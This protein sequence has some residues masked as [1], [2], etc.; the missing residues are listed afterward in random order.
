MKNQILSISQ[1]ILIEPRLER[2]VNY[3]IQVNKKAL[4][5]DIYWHNEW[6]LN[7]KPY[8]KPLIGSESD[9]DILSD[10]IYWDMIHDYLNE[11]TP[12]LL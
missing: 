3:C 9:N 8:I 11:I 10:S 12:N 7:I 1:I 6:A 2:I 4:N 5:Q